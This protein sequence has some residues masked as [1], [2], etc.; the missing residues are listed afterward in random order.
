[1]WKSGKTTLWA[2]LKAGGDLLG[3]PVRP[4]RALVLSEENLGLWCM[5]HER[6]A[7][8]ENVQL[9]CR[10]FDTKPS[11]ADWR[12]LLEES[13]K[14]L[15][16]AGARLLVIDTVATP[17]P[18]GAETNSD[19]M[20]RALAPLRRLAEHGVAVWLMHHAHKGKARAGQWSCWT[21]FMRLWSRAWRRRLL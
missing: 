21:G 2:R 19:G 10:P 1:L 8:G 13:V 3:Q 4:A 16:R 14:V 6:L 5:R 7:L 12:G 20:V 18:A 17:M 9:I 15:G 11:D